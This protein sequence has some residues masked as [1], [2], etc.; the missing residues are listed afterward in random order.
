[1]TINLLKGGLVVSCQAHFNHP[2]S[3]PSY[4]GAM[5]Q[6][7]Q[8]G[9]AVGIRADG[10]D[11][12]IE[13]KKRT[14]IPVIGIYKQHL[15]D[16][17]FFITPTLDHA[18]AIID[19]GA[20]IVAIEATFENQPDTKNLYAFI[21]TIKEDFNTP[22]MADISTFDE[23]MRAWELGADLVGTTL[24]GY[25]SISEKRSNPDFE[26]VRK[27][28]EQGVR[29]VCEGHIKTPQQAKL[30]IDNGAFFAVVGTAIT[31][32]VSIT[33]WYKETLIK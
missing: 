26:L 7:A 2:L 1:M 13:I 32:P 5:A 23:G 3:H 14:N 27:L 31:D 24:S 19:A 18:K 6:C 25:T 16:T 29:T 10:V 22:V 15:Y 11:D 4:I 9:G 8:E 28:S 17:R 30:A 21:Q 20:D 12:I 33:R